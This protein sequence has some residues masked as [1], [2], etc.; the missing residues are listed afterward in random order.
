MRIARWLCA[1]AA[2]GVPATAAAHQPVRLDTRMFVER[3]QTD[4]NGRERRVLAS[5][6]RIAP[7]DQLIFVVHWRHEG[8]TP[9]KAVAITRAVPRNARIDA[10][11]P[12]MEVSVDGGAHWGRLDRLWLPTPLGGVRRAVAEDVTHVRWTLPPGAFPGATGRLSYRAVA[13]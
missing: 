12:G 9:A 2:F 8:S 10:N 1:L 7:G 6:D 3:V 11:D 5:A 13:R 4:I